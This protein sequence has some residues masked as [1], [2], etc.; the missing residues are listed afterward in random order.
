MSTLISLHI[1]DPDDFEQEK[2]IA[3]TIENVV[4]GVIEPAAAAKVIDDTV[5]EYCQSAQSSYT[6]PP[7]ATAPTRPAGD[8]ANGVPRPTGWLKYLWDC[9]GKASMTVPADHPGQDGLVC[10]LQ[11]L[12]G[13]PKHTV[14]VKVGVEFV[15]KELWSLTA[16]NGYE[17]FEQ[18][19]WELDQGH[20]TG[21]Q[22][23]EESAAV[24]TSYLNFSAFLARLLASGIVEATRMSPLI[25]PS[26][27]ATGGPLSSGIYPEASVAAQ[28]YEPY[29]VAATQWLLHASDALFEMCSKETLIEV[30][31]QKW[32]LAL[33]NGW[34]TKFDAISRAP[35]FSPRCRRLASEALDHMAEAERAG[36][37]T[38]VVGTFGF[39]S[40]KED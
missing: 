21:T 3:M 8:G 32:T 38:D 25:R 23:I 40:M 14:P 19:L 26:P 10:L 27:F 5:V 36:V 4:N 29:A 11:A 7:G 20:F 9:L 16:D 22:Q 6:L 17:G 35:R 39:M 31:R 30:G 28:H 34:R 2:K 37:T 24:A 13:M 12:Q 33:W 15:D 1:S 18:W